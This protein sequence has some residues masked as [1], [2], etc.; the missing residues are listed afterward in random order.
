MTDRLNILFVFIEQRA[1]GVVSCSPAHTLAS[2]SL[3]RLHG[4]ARGR[5]P[6]GAQ[7]QRVVTQGAGVRLPT[8]V[9][10]LTEARVKHGAGPDIVQAAPEAGLGLL[11][12]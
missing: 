10:A 2:V 11:R 8:D 1:P 4:P 9:P 12:L 3:P 6:D 5:G 7:G